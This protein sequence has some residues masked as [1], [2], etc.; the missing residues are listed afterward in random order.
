[1]DRKIWK[2]FNKS[3]EF[4]SL[5]GYNIDYIE[6]MLDNLFSFF[7]EN[8][9]SDIFKWDTKLVFDSLMNSAQRISMDNDELSKELLDGAYSVW[10]EFL[11]FAARKNLVSISKEKMDYDLSEFERASGM[12]M[13]PMPE[14][15][16]DAVA[17]ET[18]NTMPQWRGYISKDIN[19][20][21][22]EWIDS[23]L[24]S[25][26]W[27]RRDKGVS[28]KLVE[29]AMMALTNKAYNIYRKT[30]K[31]WTKKVIH[32]V[33]TDCLPFDLDM[34][35]A[36]DY[37]HVVPALTGLLT[38]VGKEGLLSEQKVIKYGRCLVANEDE[39]L[40]IAAQSSSDFQD[41]KDSL[42]KGHNQTNRSKDS[43]DKETINAF[44]TDVEVETLYK[45]SGFEK[46]LASDDDK[47]TN[48]VQIYDPDMDKKYLN[49]L[50]HDSNGNYY[51]SQEEAIQTH[52]L[53]VQYGLKVWLNRNDYKLLGDMEALEV[54][55]DTCEVVDYIYARGTETPQHWSKSFW[56]LLAEHVKLDNS[57]DVYKRFAVV[58]KN[59]AIVL[60][61]DH[62][63]SE[64]LAYYIIK[65]L[66]T[67]GN[68]EHQIRRIKG[69]LR[70]KS[71]RK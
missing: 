44:I 4:A 53:A 54:V 27:N 10:R 48:S 2:D 29:L 62:V 28:G 13:S 60:S 40:K 49:K 55:Q 46:R 38:Y 6:E 42:E 12:K 39:M 26:D 71:K 20:Y 19:E 35:E 69:K 15:F 25:T 70:K 43:N 14:I 3:T 65:C 59:L 21:T 56:K 31:S 30:P 68:H 63:I 67:K 36:N 51:W 18:G 58:W 24:E 33:L 16:N 5:T 8:G 11:E 57:Y 47:L 66:R 32:D 7:D 1:M 41:L 61:K 50:H 52:A 9:Y 17:L 23:Y 34:L 22:H 37:S 64:Q 45:D